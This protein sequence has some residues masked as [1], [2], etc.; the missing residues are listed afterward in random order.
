MVYKSKKIPR[1]VRDRNRRMAVKRN[2]KMFAKIIREEPPKGKAKIIA[3]EEMIK[4][5]QTGK[6]KLQ[7]VYEVKKEKNPHIKADVLYIPKVPPEKERKYLRKELPQFKN[8]PVRYPNVDKYGDLKSIKKNRLIEIAKTEYDLNEK[9]AKYFDK[10]DLIKY[11][12]D[13]S[14]GKIKAPEQYMPNKVRLARIEP[15]RNEPI[16]FK[17]DPVDPFNSQIT[18]GKKTVSGNKAAGETAVDVMNRTWASNRKWKNIPKI[19]ETRQFDKRIHQQFVAGTASPEDLLSEIMLHTDLPDKQKTD[20]MYLDP[21]QLGKIYKKLYK[22]SLKP[23]QE[24]F[25]QVVRLPEFNMSNVPRYAKAPLFKDPKGDTHAVGTKPFP[26]AI[27]PLL[28]Y[29]YIK[30]YN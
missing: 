30:Q 4:D 28:P 9:G 18:Y 8:A 25:K 12:E 13:R 7:T 5:P 10:D 1:V 24:K 14:K 19:G 29:D 22:T 11:L 15:I 3:R 17:I 2:D 26:Y 23:E 6:A 27:N 20:L 21:D 16:R